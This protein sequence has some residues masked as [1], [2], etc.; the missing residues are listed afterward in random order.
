MSIFVNLK[1]STTSNPL[2]KTRAGFIIALICG[3]KFLALQLKRMRNGSIKVLTI[4][5][6]V[7]TYY[8]GIHKFK[9]KKLGIISFQEKLKSGAQYFA[10]LTLL[11]A[12]ALYVSD[13]PERSKTRYLTI[14]DN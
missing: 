7:P 12:L 4:I 3:V 13:A 14:I 6:I 8:V 9:K 11:P 10:I 1:R 5:C 2:I